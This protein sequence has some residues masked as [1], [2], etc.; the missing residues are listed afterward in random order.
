MFGWGANNV[1][2]IGDGTEIDR[3]SPV[4]PDE[5]GP[6]VDVSVS[7]LPADGSSDS[8]HSLAV[9]ANGTLWAWGDNSRG[10]LG[11]G[12]TQNRAKPT[13]VGSAQD[14]KAVAAGS[15]FPWRSRRTVKSG[16]GV[17]TAS[18]RSGRG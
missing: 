8:A 5:S 14:W 4:V 10:Q 15:G 1:G 13:R 16:S 7:L 2:Q 12:D 11:Q 17:I 3:S 6:W 18:V 9:K